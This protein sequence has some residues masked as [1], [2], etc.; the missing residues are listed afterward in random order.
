[1]KA[2]WRS[3]KQCTYAGCELQATHNMP[4]LPAQFCDH[5]KLPDMVH[6]AQ[7]RTQ[8]PT[9]KRTYRRDGCIMEGCTVYASFNFQ[10]MVPKF[11]KK[12]KVDGMMRVKKVAPPQT[13]GTAPMKRGPYKKRKNKKSKGRT[14]LNEPQNTP[15]RT[16]TKVAL[17]VDSPSTEQLMKGRLKTR[18]ND[19][20]ARK[21][22]KVVAVGTKPVLATNAFTGKKVRLPGLKKSGLVQSARQMH[23]PT[24]AIAQR[25]STMGRCT[26]DGCIILACYGF[27]DSQA[28]KCSMHRFEGMILMV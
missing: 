18:R 14:P 7:V 26:Q 27:E 23:V 1:M 21:S 12:H 20:G 8:A 17:N 11:C 9:P 15:A 19:G 28:T 6:S 16:I 2:C 4:G 3:R 25:E 5:H 24:P 22:L 13:E 10:G